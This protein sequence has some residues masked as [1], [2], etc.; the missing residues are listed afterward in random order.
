MGP[1]VEGIGLNVTAW[2][3]AG[4][5]TF[6]LL[7]CAD[8]VDDIWDLTAA[9]RASVDELRGRILV[10]LIGSGRA[11]PAGRSASGRVSVGTFVPPP[12]GPGGDDRRDAPAR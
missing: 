5:M 9:L 6:A 8:H 3:Y 12:P 11:R 4:A 10:G 1:L 2:S 7:A